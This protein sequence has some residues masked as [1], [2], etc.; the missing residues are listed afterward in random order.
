MKVGDTLQLG[1]EHTA[2]L[3]TVEGIVTYSRT[4]QARGV[5]ITTQ[6]GVVLRCSDTAPIWTDQGYVNAP[7]LK[8]K[9]VAVR[10]DRMSGNVTRFELVEVVEDLGI[11]DVQHITVSD[12]AF[13][14][15]DGADAYLL[16]HN[17]KEY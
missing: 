6:S 12:R 1:D 15:G 3:R 14:A 17:L 13:W 2:D 9:R 11:I 8:G 16:H 10:V 5:R 4:T 7:D